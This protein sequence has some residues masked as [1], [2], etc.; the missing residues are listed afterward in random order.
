MKIFL[1]SLERGDTEYSLAIR[2]SKHLPDV[3]NRLLSLL[4]R[5]PKNKLKYRENLTVLIDNQ[6]GV[7]FLKSK[8]HPLLGI[9]FLSNKDY[10]EENTLNE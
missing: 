6:E 3:F 4:R 8:I 1:T 10:F 5:R 9:G 7:T 2:V